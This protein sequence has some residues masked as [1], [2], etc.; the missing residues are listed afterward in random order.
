MLPMRPQSLDAFFVEVL[1]NTPE[2]DVRH[3]RL[4]L[5]ASI[6]KALP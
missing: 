5:L 4:A 2:Q 1:V 6:Q 3:N